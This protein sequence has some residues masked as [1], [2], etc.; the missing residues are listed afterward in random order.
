MSQS[1]ALVLVHIIFL[2]QKSNAFLQSAEL[3]SEVHAYEIR[4]EEPYDQMEWKNKLSHCTYSASRLVCEVPGP[5]SPGCSLFAPLALR[6]TSPNSH[7]VTGCRRKPC[8]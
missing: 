1:L 2:H 8:S 3:R 6:K 5:I 4:F 7:H